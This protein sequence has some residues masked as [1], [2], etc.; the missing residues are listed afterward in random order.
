MAIY[1]C[2]MHN[3]KHRCIID[4]TVMI[5]APTMQEATE[6]AQRYFERSEGEEVP[7]EQITLM[8]LEVLDHRTLEFV[9]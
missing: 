6:A 8:P 9:V 3:V 4:E 1:Q 2:N 7:P 5:S